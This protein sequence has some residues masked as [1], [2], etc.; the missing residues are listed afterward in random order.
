MEWNQAEWA[1]SREEGQEADLNGIIGEV[2]KKEN[3]KWFWS[4]K[5]SGKRSEFPEIFDCGTIPTEY[6]AKR[7]AEASMKKADES[8]GK[9][10][11]ET[12]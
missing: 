12:S 4:V 7:C 11:Q 8:Y 3:G 1:D 9:P 2:V 10:F 5:P 6:V